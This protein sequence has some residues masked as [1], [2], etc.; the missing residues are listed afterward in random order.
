MGQLLS[1]GDQ[2]S[3]PLLIAKQQ[4]LIKTT[5]RAEKAKREAAILYLQTQ[6]LKGKVLASQKQKSS[7]K[8]N[9]T[10]PLSSSIVKNETTTTVGAGETKETKTTTTISSPARRVSSIPSSADKGQF[11]SGISYNVKEFNYFRDEVGFN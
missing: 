1:C 2:S 11:N 3:D 4:E 6:E 5:K 9:T 8:E 7:K 10:T